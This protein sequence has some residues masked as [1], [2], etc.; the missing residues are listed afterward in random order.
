MTNKVFLGIVVAATA[1]LLI[2]LTILGQNQAVS[3]ETP[4]TSEMG[5]EMG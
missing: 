1:G 5:E 3:Q 4:V 2:P